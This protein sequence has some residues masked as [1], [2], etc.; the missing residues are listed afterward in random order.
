MNQ[1]D[2]LEAGFK[3][4]GLLG[5]TDHDGS[6][7]PEKQQYKKPYA[8][9]WQHTPDWSDD[10]LDVMEESGQF[11]TGFGVLCD[12]WLIID[13][14]PRNGGTLESVKHWHKQAGFVVKTGGGGWHIYFKS[15]GGAFVQ[16]LDQFK[17]IDFKTSG[18]VVGAGSMHASGTIYE[19]E[20]GHP[21]D[22]KE[23]P[24]DLIE[25]LKKPD[26][27][28]AQTNSGM[29]DVSYQELSDMVNHIRNDDVDYEV[30]IRIGMAIHHT[31]SGDGFEIWDDWSRKS[32]KYN[33]TFMLTKWHSFGKSSLVA[34]L[35]T[36]IHYAELGGYQQSVTFETTLEDDSE[37]SPPTVDLLRPPGF[38]GELATWINSQCFFPRENLSV[39]AALGV[40]SA[41]AGMR[42]RDQTGITPNLF[43]L[44]VAGS[45]TG[46]EAIQQAFADCLRAAGMAPALHGHIK[47]EQEMIRNFIRHQAAHYCIDEF[48]MFLKTVVT[49]ASKGGASYLEGV[50]KV[51]LSAYTK[52]DG[53]LQ[54]SGDL[55]EQ[56][57]T[58]IKNELAACYK[59]IDN[60][61]DQSGKFQAR[62]EHLQR[63]L[64]DIDN[65]IKNPFI[66]L[67]GFTTPVTFNSLVSFEM[68]TNG[69][70]GRSLI[71][72]E[73]ET[74]PRPNKKRA[75]KGMPTNLSMQL[76]ALFNCG[77]SSDLIRIENN[78]AVVTVQDTKEAESLLQDAAEHF[79]QCAED[80]KDYGLEAIHRRGYE[81]T[82]KVSLV[83]A[84]A[85]GVRTREHVLWAYELVKRDCAT[86]MRL[87]RS[88]DVEKESPGESIAVKI[89]QFLKSSGEFE[90]EGVI[91]NRCRPHKKEQV[92]QILE[93]LVSSKRVQCKKSVNRKNRL[94]TNK[95]KAL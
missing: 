39:A 40:V 66:T 19:V 65:G 46:K 52:A 70:V 90:T 69:F 72:N 80:A 74:N 29:M 62:A 77:D 11:A 78:G 59:K 17:G 49:S 37:D 63:H 24:G 55:K 33:N 47:S 50:V 22:V 3:V 71:F 14:D 45:G 84:I 41:I 21:C 82:A 2:Y 28:R 89:E 93:K 18:Y 26:R 5:K 1:F 85:E 35:G 34:G 92:L 13:I 23:A 83:L 81:L 61:E 64:K 87:A 44:C 43:S 58:D 73:H 53:Y 15:P 25:L 36:I 68:A 94:E 8:S 10:Q 88:N 60:N 6:L 27:Y 38:V 67:I 7:L 12:G 57:K 91:V 16:H 9:N 48:G 95:Y 79:W 4:F 30:W 54:I 42:Y 56:V 20:S 76:S 75:P 31:L 51:M 86:K 32:D